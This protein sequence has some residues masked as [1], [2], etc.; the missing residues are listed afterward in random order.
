MGW[1]EEKKSGGRRRL[2][3]RVLV[4]RSRQADLC[5]PGSW[6]SGEHAVIAWDG[7]EWKIRDLGSRNGTTVDGRPLESRS[8]R[9]MRRGAVVAFGQVEEQWVLADTSPPIPMGVADDQCVQAIDRVLTLPDDEHPQVT[10][11]RDG[12]RWLAEKGDDEQEEVTDRD[13]LV[14][15]GRIWRLRLPEA[16][17]ITKA[18]IG[19]RRLADFRL[20]LAI[21]RDE[22]V[23]QV[24]LLGDSHRII[25]EPRTHHYLL[26]VLAR[27][28]LDQRAAGLS[29]AEAGWLDPEELSRMLRLGRTSINVYIHRIRGQ[30]ADVGI[31][32]GKNIIER[33]PGTFALRVAPIEIT[34]VSL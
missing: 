33:Q 3:P 24:R 7:A 28:A 29:M 13:A 15:D 5:L 2:A 14:V 8:D 21:S 12:D 17:E 31:F 4:G 10:V 16:R 34:I 6:V 22:E 25:L 11:Y 23:V 27:H 32:D 1:I 19:S 30:V 26:V 18:H 20:E 9:V